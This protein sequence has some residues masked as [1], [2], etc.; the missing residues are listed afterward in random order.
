M[1]KDAGAARDPGDDGMGTGVGLGTVPP[2][3]AGKE[4]AGTP[5]IPEVAGAIRD[6]GGGPPV[7]G[8][9]PDP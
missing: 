3:G 5:P 4:E 8:A 2:P 7:V 1:L 9:L 6:D